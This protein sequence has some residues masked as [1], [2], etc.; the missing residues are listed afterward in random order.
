MPVIRPLRTADHAALLRINAASTPA[1]AQLDAVELQR[2]AEIG[3]LHFVA[4]DEGDAVL[5]YV[6]AF[7]HNE[8][9]DGEEFRHFTGRIAGPF[10]YVDQIAIAAPDQRSGIGQALY[11]CLAAEAQRRRLTLLCCEVN[12]IPPNAASMTFHLRLGFR[13]LDTIAVS[14]GRTVALLARAASPF[15]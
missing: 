13:P 5:G 3:E 1:V 9:Y 7:A 15:N 6:L 11:N 12:T 2:L 8:A 4:V 14:D 10:L